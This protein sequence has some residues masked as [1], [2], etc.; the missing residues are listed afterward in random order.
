M[1]IRL[2]TFIALTGF[3]LTIGYSQ[4]SDRF[5]KWEEKIANFEKR[6]KES[7]PPKGCLLFVGSSSIRMWDLEGSWPD[8]DTVN[9]GF[10][11]STIADSIHFFDRVIAPYQPRA[12]I[13]YAGDN[14]INKGLSAEGTLQ[15]FD[16]LSGKIRSKF[17]SVPILF[18]A[19]KPSRKRWEIW[20]EMKKAND[21][22][23]K[24]CSEEKNMVFVDTASAMLKGNAG[25]PNEKWFVEDGL[26]LSEYGYQV[27]TGMVSQALAE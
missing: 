21:L 2:S 26:H 5:A 9:N 25:P 6:D 11:G 16:T 7:P 1:K 10:G 18:L 8:E 3:C 20:P 24:R 19:I 27:W 13:L 15:D 12:V 14:D 22:I 4:D 17:P 23:A